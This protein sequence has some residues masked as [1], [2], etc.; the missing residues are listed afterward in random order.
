MQE[1]N[2]RD[3]PELPQDQDLVYASAPRLFLVPDPFTARAV[4]KALIIGV[5]FP[6]HF[7]IVFQV[8]RTA[9]YEGPAL[10]VGVGAELKRSS[11]FPT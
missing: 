1:N 11:W 6:S 4:M 3:V 5:P 8:F 9:V 10:F 2:K 7:A